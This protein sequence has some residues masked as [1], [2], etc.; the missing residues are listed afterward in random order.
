MALDENNQADI[1]FQEMMKK[2]PSGIEA[3]LEYLQF[4]IKMGN[5]KGSQQLAGIIL[6]KLEIS[7]QIPTTIWVECHQE[8]AKLEWLLGHLD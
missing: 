3:N 7:E 2:Y 8:V 5:M 4:L 6:K 1:I